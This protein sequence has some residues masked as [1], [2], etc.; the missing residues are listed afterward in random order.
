MLPSS[1]PLDHKLCLKDINTKRP[2][3]VLVKDGIRQ[4]SQFLLN[5]TNNFVPKNLWKSTGATKLHHTIQQVTLHVTV[6]EE[7][8]ISAQ[9]F[10]VENFPLVC[11]LHK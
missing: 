10:I 3:T 11:T 6:I 4:T 9:S 8:R 1:P 7:L 2:N 5:S